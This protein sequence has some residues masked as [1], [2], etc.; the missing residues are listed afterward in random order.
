MTVG[1][2]RFVVVN[3]SPAIFLLTFLVACN[4][5]LG[6]EERPP[7][8]TSGAGR[9][10]DAGSTHT[11]CAVCEADVPGGWSGPTAVTIA[12]AAPTCETPDL[13][14]IELALHDES[15][16]PSAECACACDDAVGVNCDA[17]PVQITHYS[18]DDCTNVNETATGTL[19]NCVSMC[20]GGQ[21]A[22]YIEPAADVSTASC[23]STTLADTKAAPAWARH[24]VGCGPVESEDCGGDRCFD[25]RGDSALCI[26]RSGDDACPPGPFSA[27]S[28]WY[29]SLDDTRGCEPCGCGPVDVSDCHA[30]VRGYTGTNCDAADAL[31]SPAPAPPCTE[32]PIDFDS[33]RVESFAPTGSCTPT[34]PTTVCCLP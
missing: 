12:D 16:S 23:V 6:L 10:G 27:R 29:A 25:Q 14:N 13:G 22:N 9:G 31:L 5:V 26:Y 21:S 8:E 15:L 28:I 11:E 17:S 20:C 18:N 19:G 3:R 34:Q 4:A 1:V 33:A 32:A 7:Q 30:V 2:A 24:L